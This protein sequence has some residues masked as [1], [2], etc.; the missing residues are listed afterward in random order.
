M[1]DHGGRGNKGGG[2]NEGGGDG[3][4]VSGGEN[5]GGG[6]GLKVSGGEKDGVV[7]KVYKTYF[8]YNNCYMLQIH[9]D[10]E[11][12]KSKQNYNLKK[13]LN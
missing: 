11:I 1:S 6:D 2:E 7:E 8:H 9:I 12:L 10:I 5:E 3:L 13:Q 4:K